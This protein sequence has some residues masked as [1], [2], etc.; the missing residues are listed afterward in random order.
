M[1]LAGRERR[2]RG[3]F[4]R[5]RA[6][7]LDVAPRAVQHDRVV[8]Q[9][10][11][12]APRHP[13]SSLASKLKPCAD[14]ASRGSD[15]FQA[16]RIAANQRRRVPERRPVAI[17]SVAS[18]SRSSRSP[19]K[20]FSSERSASRRARSGLDGSSSR[21]S[22]PSMTAILRRRCA[23]KAVEAPVVVSAARTSKL[24]RVDLGRGPC[25]FEQGSPVRAHAAT[26]VGHR[27]AEERGSFEHIGVRR[28]ARELERLGVPTE[29][30][31][32]ASLVEGPVGGDPR[33]SARP[34]TCQSAGRPLRPVV[35]E[36]GRTRRPPSTGDRLEL[37]AIA[38]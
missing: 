5:W 4:A 28:F 36:L 13:P 37:L 24:H 10:E 20:I 17:A 26:A 31:V 35:R 25:R 14:R 9:Y 22:A 11:G 21:A 8:G 23:G 1:E 33:R 12:R 29:R 3:R 15:R 27:R 16:P 34:W 6:E 32:R 2:C 38:R 30:L 18:A 7:S 19:P